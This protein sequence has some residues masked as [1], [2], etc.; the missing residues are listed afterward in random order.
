MPPPL[1]PA[2]MQL[3][4]EAMLAH[5]A[6]R[7]A[8]AEVLYRKVLSTDARQFPVLSM[9]GLVCA[10]RRNFVEAERFFGEALK[11]NPQ[12]A[13]GQFNYGN[14][15]LG[16]Q[17]LD[18]AFAAFGK[19]LALNPA[20]AE[21]HLNRG[22]IFMFRKRFE[23]AIA[24]FDAAIRIKP[25]S[26]EAHCNRGHALEEIRRFDEALVSCETAL[27]LNSRNAEFHAAR[28]NILHRLKREEDALIGVSTALS[29]QPANAS[30]Q[31]NRGNLLFEL[32]RF[33]EAFEA[34][35]KAFALEPNLEYAESAR[36]HTKMRLCDW[37]DFDVECAHLA[38]SIEKEIV[39]QPFPVLA[40]SASPEVQLLSASVL[41]K[42]KYAPSE[43]P[44]WD[45]ERYDHDRIR[46][47][48]LSADFAEHAVSI[49]L[50]DVFE[51]HD[52]KR[53]ETFAISFETHKPGETLARMKKS[54][55]HFIDVQGQS[56]IDVA[57]LLRKLE[58]DIAVDLMGYTK[59]LRTSIFAFRPAPI[60]LNYLG[61]PGTMG[62][63]Y[64]D[65]IIAD[66]FII[67]DTQL[68]FYAEQIVYLPDCFQAND[69]KRSIGVAPSSRTEAGLPETAFVFCSFNNSFKITPACFEIWMRL[70]NQVEGSVIWLLGGDDELEHNLRRKAENL[71]VHPTRLIFSP[72][73]AYAS[74]LARYRLADLF[75]D[76]FPFNGGTT[77]SDAL[78]TGLP[79]ITCAGKTFASRMAGS[80]LHAVGLPELVTESFVEYEALALNLSR[81]P[82]R[83]S[84][85]KAKLARNRNSHPLFNP[86][87]FTRHLEAAFEI[88][89]GRV[90]QGKPPSSFV[91][92]PID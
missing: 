62:A 80:L 77:A 87:R 6:G 52:R 17:R 69:S 3:V 7:L 50:A 48:Y 61:Y 44:L 30:F 47:A 14:V 25:D 32:N 5:Q 53:F 13:D 40:I 16:L 4:R 33:A 55:D 86:A 67:P 91:V 15:L 88:M 90:Q 9:L 24:C 1:P 60:Q 56:D 2:A 89:C 75:L 31:Y 8:E 34:Y 64:I 84:A 26:A 57:R 66:R 27:A 72:R 45:G 46:V 38:L 29:L 23:E 10:Q 35:D 76:T 70:L 28:A 83:L 85:I 19:A 63:D 58:I 11:L 68:R 49:L 73:A 21:A 51:Q 59:G 22:N 36:L 37:R 43:N 71:G 79:V 78:W 81:N 18:D 74:Y 82:D 12:D 41:S 39:S 65:Y 20:L 42:I 54:F 92:E